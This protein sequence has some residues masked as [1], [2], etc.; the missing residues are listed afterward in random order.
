METF[1]PDL[2]VADSAVVPAFD[3]AE[4]LGIPCLVQMQ[5]LGHY[6]PISRK[7]PRYSFDFGMRMSFAQ[8]VINS[9]YPVLLA[10]YL[11]ELRRLDRVRRRA[12]GS[13]ALQSA[14]FRLDGYCLFR[15][16]GIEIPRALPPLCKMVGPVFPRQPKPISPELKTWLED[17]NR[18]VIYMSFGTLA[19]LE[20]WQAAALLKGL[21][22]PAWRV[23]WAL[24]PAEQHLLE[25]VPPNFRVE[26]FVPQ[27]AVLGEPAVQLF[28]S[29]CG[30]NSSSECLYH[31][32]PILA[33][34]FFGDQHYNAARLDDIGAG[35]RL[36]KQRFH[37][38]E[39]RSK[40][41][42]LL[43]DR[44]YTAAARRMAA[45]LRQMR[46]REDAVKTIQDALDFGF[47]HLK[48]ESLYAQ[49]SPARPKPGADCHHRN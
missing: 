37:A 13:K 5:F 11:P 24:R 4:A 3:L 22:S 35:L 36:R 31:G 48:P 15:F 2:L 9:L 46:G 6:A 28:V 21:T 1:Q 8:R 10:Y 40:V 25:T 27:P 32:K 20:R 17:G 47:A 12:G 23:L 7:Y 16:R 42:L 18:P 14:P 19:T 34:P 41:Q 43:R 26:G 33:L 30:L 39:V 49:A 29:H 45:V 38:E 44:S